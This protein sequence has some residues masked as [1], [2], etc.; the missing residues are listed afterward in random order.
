MAT[1]LSE[2]RQHHDSGYSV[3]EISGLTGMSRPLIYYWL[4]NWG[5]TPNI[6]R[7]PNLNEYQLGS[8]FKLHQRGMS[9]AAIGRELGIPTHQVRYA[10]RVTMAGGFV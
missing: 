8:I 3:L 6:N 2:V 10:L 4:H 7:R 5:L 9:Q 1:T